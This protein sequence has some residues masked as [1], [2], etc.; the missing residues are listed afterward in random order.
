[1]REQNAM[2]IANPGIDCKKEINI[3]WH[4]GLDNKGSYLEY[5][6][7]GEKDWKKVFPTISKVDCFNN[8]YSVD[9]N[10]NDI[11]EEVI[12]LHCKVYL[13]NLKV[14]TN[15]EYRIDSSEERHYFKTSPKDEFSFI[16]ISDFHSYPPA[17]NR[18]EN[19]SNMIDKISLKHQ[20]ADFVFCSGD[21]IAWGGSYSFWKEFYNIPSIKKYMWAN[22]LGNHDYMSRAYEKN[23]S[24]YFKE[25]N[26][27]PK[28]GYK[29][30]IG[31]CY[32][33][34]YG[35]SLF[36]VMHNEHMG[37]NEPFNE[38]VEKAIN[39]VEKVIKNNPAKHIFLCQHYQWINGVNGRDRAFGYERWKTICDKYHIELAIAANDHTYIRTYPIF[40][41]EIVENGTVY[42]QCPS[43]DGDRGVDLEEPMS[44]P[45]KKI[46]FRYATGLN[47]IAGIFVEVKNNTIKTILYDRDMN[48]VDENIIKS[49]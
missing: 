4:T 11:R 10:R 46:A 36:I 35:N 15:Y 7:I 17:F 6:E 3:S 26:N 30:E 22:T 1:M 40:A 28:N 16:W 2:I 41:D 44:Y 34:K 32:Y 45:N 8:V 18:L 5:R 37:V 19:A 21:S 27:F 9:K 23:T 38:N 20:N 48:I 49:E 31:V 24:D 14:N 42:M 25:V 47:T 39:W 33:F 12:F 29:G 13:K 43:S